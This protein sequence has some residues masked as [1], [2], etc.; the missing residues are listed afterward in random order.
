MIKTADG[1][2]IMELADKEIEL[3]RYID[4]LD[5]AIDEVQIAMNILREHYGVEFCAVTV[6]G[7]GDHQVHLKCGIEELADVLKREV[8]IYDEWRLSKEFRYLWT[9]Y[10]QLA[11]I[12]STNFLPLNYR[13]K[14]LNRLEEPKL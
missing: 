13:G 14:A 6:S 12:N 9:R 3:K 1:G 7:S 11:E 2:Y 10:V 5:H 4:R 8:K